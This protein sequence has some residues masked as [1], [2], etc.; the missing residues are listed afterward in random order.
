MLKPIR[1]ILVTGFL[2]SGKTTLVN[3]L[4]RQLPPQTRL[5]VLMNEFA[6]IGVDAA[7]IERVAGLE[8]IEVRKGSIFCICAKNEFI[9]G[10]THVAE[11]LTP[12]YLLIEATGVANPTDIRKDLSL[13]LFKG[14]FHFEQ[15]IC[16]VDTVNFEAAYYVFAAVE[17]QIATSDLFILNK[18]DLATADQRQTVRELIAAHRPSPNIIET[19]QAKVP[20]IQIL[21][22]IE[23]KASMGL[24]VPQFEQ[25]ASP[26]QLP[27]DRML[28][29]IYEW[30][31]KSRSELDHCLENCPDSLARCK[32][33]VELDGNG[34]LID[35]VMGRFTVTPTRKPM[36]ELAIELRNRLVVIAAPEVFGYLD[37]LFEPHLLV[38]Q[39]THNPMVLMEMMPGRT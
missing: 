37:K 1:V 32:G 6:E 39:S 9:R 30:K 15:Q 31:G 22:T 11:Q 21:H 17:H 16:L 14:R 29:A 13:P 3:Q 19:F 35:G 18:T 36:L 38:R 8:I 12:E 4:I 25:N 26:H 24:A 2:G 28:S 20:L 33:F 5:S 10:L 34:Y 27:P 7:L 23:S